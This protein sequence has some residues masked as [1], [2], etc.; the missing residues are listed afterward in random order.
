MTIMAITTI[1]VL[2]TSIMSAAYSS[3]DLSTKG[4]YSQ[5]N[6]ERSASDYYAS[7]DPNAKDLELKKQLQKLISPHKVLSYDNVWKAFADVGTHSPHYPCNTNKTHIPDVFLSI[8]GHPIT[9]Q[10]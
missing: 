4:Q 5:D 10:Q 6:R 1:L 2:L 3:V 7:I 8:A 9:P